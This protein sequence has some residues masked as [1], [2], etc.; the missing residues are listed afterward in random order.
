LY[1]SNEALA[2]FD[3]T[4][5]S[6]HTHFDLPADQQ[7]ERLLKAMENKHLNII[8][9]P[10]GRKVVGRPPYNLDLNR[11][12]EAAADKNCILEINSHPSRL[13]LNEINAKKAKNKGVKL[14]ISTDAHS[15]EELSYVKYGIYQ[16]RRGW[17]EKDDVVNTHN[18]DDLR[19]LLSR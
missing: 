9:H 2:K 8:A 15:I 16:A 11:V 13:D 5:G 3:F 7:T 12:F 17:I 19:N 18:L 1:F 14:A 10:T 6:I 4:V